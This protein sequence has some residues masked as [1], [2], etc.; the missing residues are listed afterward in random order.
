M[1]DELTN[2]CIKI[3]LLQVIK[4]IQ[5]FAKTIK[6]LCIRKPRKKEKILKRFSW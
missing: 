1:L 5:I 4:E 2:I 3:P 6:E